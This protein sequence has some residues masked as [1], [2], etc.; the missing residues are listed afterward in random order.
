MSPA[1]S[2]RSPRRPGDRTSSGATP[3]RGA[4]SDRE[5]TL[6]R[7]DL[8]FLLAQVERVQSGRRAAGAGK[9]PSKADELEL[10]RLRRLVTRA[11]VGDDD[12]G[13]PDGDEWDANDEW[14]EGAD[15]GEPD[16]YEEPDPFEED[17]GDRW[18]PRR[19]WER[20]APA[21]PIKV[22]GGLTTRSRRGAI[23]ESWWSK[24]FLD[25]IESTMAGGRSTRGRSYARG[26]QV[27]ELTVSAGR[28]T[29]LVQGTRRTP[30]R[31]E[32]AMRAA[33]D[34]EWGR[35]VTALAGQ[36]GYAARLLAG[37]IPHELEDVFAAQG[38]P[39]LP[40]RTSRL[41]T[42]CTCPDWANPCKHV[43]AVCYLVAE[44]FDRDP[45]TLLA[46]RGRSR[47]QLLGALR[48]LRV[49]E[50][51]AAAEQLPV[52]TASSSPLSEC[53]LGY[54]KAGPELAGVR[55]RPE[56]DEA[57]G[58]VLRQLPRGVLEVRGRDVADLLEPAYAEMA[59][60]AER[61]AFVRPRQR[62]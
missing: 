28:F 33:D 25:A 49:G 5:A 30:Y 9:G 21:K 29:A 10:T 44:E 46:W 12:A 57:A 59:S 20:F 58:A 31:V 43:G 18:W 24:R 34:D 36:A 41:A 56:A 35:V 53:L 14:D 54:W 48:E 7:S 38:V 3:G 16:P 11:I 45:F 2:G 37:E 23:G 26:G 15:P 39:L 32:V 6:R 61:R 52:P 40:S 13:G 47:E 17:D 62:D 55:I 8:E 50:G 27:L 51:S 4:R 60:A 22:E 19:S 42:D 1:R